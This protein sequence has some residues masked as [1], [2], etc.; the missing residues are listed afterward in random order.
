MI[1]LAA[2]KPLQH[3]SNAPE[4]VKQKTPHAATSRRESAIGATMKIGRQRWG[5]AAELA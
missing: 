4:S 3:L 1:G 2:K 5:D